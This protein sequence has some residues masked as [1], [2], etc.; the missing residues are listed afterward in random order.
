MAHYKK[1]MSKREFE[2]GAVRDGADNKPNFLDY[3]DPL[4]LWRFGKYMKKAEVKYGRGNWKKGIPKKEYLESLKRHLEKEIAA[5]D[6]GD[7]MNKDMKEE[8]E[9]G[10]DHA[11]G[12]MFNIIGYMYA[13][14]QEQLGTK[15]VAK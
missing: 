13:Q 10:Y 1:L 2:T 6:Y 5:L 15:S 8:M 4:V 11:S 14:I 7:K 12:M 9:Y 3:L